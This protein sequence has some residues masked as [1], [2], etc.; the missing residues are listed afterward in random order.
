MT[1]DLISLLARHPAPRTDCSDAFVNTEL[2]FAYLGM[3]QT[4]QATEI[5]KRAVAMPGDLD[6]PLS[7]LVLLEL[8][9]LL[10][11]SGD[12]KAAANCFEEATYSAYENGEFGTLE[13]AF[14]YGQESHVRAQPRN[15]G[16]LRPLNPAITW[17]KSQGRARELHA[18]LL[19]STAENALLSDQPAVAS[20]ALSEAKAVIGRRDMLYGEVGARLSYL[21]AM[22]NYQQGNA[23]GGDGALADALA[24]QKRGSKWLFQISLADYFVHSQFGPH[25]GGT[26]AMALFDSLLHDPTS[27]DWASRPL[28]SL[29]VLSAPDAAVYEHWFELAHQEGTEIS[30]D[31]ADRARRHRFLSTLPLGGRLQ[32]L[33]W[34]LES[35]AAGLDQAAQVQRADLLARYPKYAALS[36]QAAELRAELAAAPLV[37]QGTSAEHK[38]SAEFA[39]LS[40]LSVQQESLLRQFALGRN[41]ADFAFPPLHK[42]KEIQNSLGPRQLLLMF[43]T[44]GNSTYAWAVSKSRIATW[45]VETGPLEKK[46]A[47]LLRA[48]GNMDANRDVPENQ[49]ADDVAWRQAAREAT[50]AMLGDS[51]VI[52]EGNIDELIVVPDGALWYLPF[53]ALQV[54][55]GPVRVRNDKESVPL[56]SRTRVRYLPTMGLALPDRSER[57]PMDQMG[58]VLGKLN[59]HEEPAAVQAEFDRFEKVAPHVSPLKRLAADDLPGLRRD[60]R[61]AGGARRPGHQSESGRRR[62]TR[63]QKSKLRMVADSTRH[64]SRRRR[65][66]A[67]V[68]VA[69]EKP[70]ADYA[71]RFPYS[72]RERLAANG[73]RPSRQRPVSHR[74]RIDVDR[75]TDGADQP[76]EN[77][78]GDQLRPDARVRARA[79]LFRRGRVLAAQRRTAARFAPR[80]CP[81]AARP[82]IPEFRSPNGPAPILLVG[83]PADRHRLVAAGGPGGRG[84]EKVGRKLNDP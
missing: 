3:G 24:F 73:F 1:S 61:F 48:I 78:R 52:L 60:V 28:E 70:A 63:G 41:G 49:L 53:E 69:L 32:S 12:Y 9:E 71:P 38:Q 18:S 14:R 17:S 23:R 77:R 66:V 51:K 68:C 57:R 25:L 59:A 13:E 33:R 15:P 65:I 83:L 40:R 4:R 37:P 50:D 31:V 75:S 72:G 30:L 43:F 58:V 10:L 82:A 62:Q 35:P 64:G 76:L 11:Q 21:S 45:R 46:I 81:R 74:L 80:S 26:R 16:L 5:L 19:L 47:N 34:I 8:G 39:E 20:S 84:E 22:L 42:T 56:L 29:A 55:T 36:K 7:G 6:H 67:M 44:S 2:G 79:S 54:S 27:A